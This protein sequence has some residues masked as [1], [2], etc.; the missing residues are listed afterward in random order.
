[1]SSPARFHPKTWEDGVMPLSEFPTEKQQVIARAIERPTPPPRWLNFVGCRMESRA[2]FEWHWSRGLKLSKKP[3]YKPRTRPRISDTLRM[4]VYDRDGWACL[5]CGE[6]ESLSLDHIHPFS[7][8]G[9]DA[10]ENLQTLC[11]SC[12]SKKG[13]RV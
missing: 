12:N 11:R 4:K 6:T 5:H 2:W 9:S 3:G 10:F 1:M 7:L 13:A 8:G